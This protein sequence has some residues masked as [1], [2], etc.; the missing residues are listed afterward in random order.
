MNINTTA[1]LIAHHT[2]GV[3]AAQVRVIT[4]RRA[5]Q[6]K[7]DRFNTRGLPRFVHTPERAA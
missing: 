3:A 2:E 1:G 5:A 7:Q 6:A 4:A